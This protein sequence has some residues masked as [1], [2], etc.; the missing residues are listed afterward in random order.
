MSRISARKGFT[1]I[2]LLVVIAIIA[3][4]A[5][6]LFP[7]FAQAREKARQTSCLSNVKQMGLA[8]MMYAQDYDETLYPHRFNCDRNNDGVRDNCPQYEDANGNLV[9]PYLNYDADSRQRFY[10]VHML[11]PYTKN[12]QIF[13]C[14][15]NPNAFYPGRDDSAPVFNAPGAK[16]K[17]YGGQNSYG[18]NDGWLSPANPFDPGVSKVGTVSL[19]SIDRPAGVVMVTDAKYYGVLPDYL[20]E[21][22]LG[23]TVRFTGDQRAKIETYINPDGKGSQYKSYWKNI[24]NANWSESGGTL[25]AATALK[26]MQGR[27]SGLINCQFADGHAKAI[28]YKALITDLCLWSTGADGAGLNCN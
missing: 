24:G 4:L 3:I 5:A 1:L 13:Q 9:A 11:Q 22:G 2:E 18:H 25:D 21:S 12:Y 7:V 27:H 26:L 10:W 23:D 6:I 15:S 8:S 19:A 17:A 28:Q 16:G 20:N 14:P